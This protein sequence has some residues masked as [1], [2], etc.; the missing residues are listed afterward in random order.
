MSCIQSIICLGE[1]RE[2]DNGYHSYDF[3]IKLTDGKSYRETF[4]DRAGRQSTQELLNVL[5]ARGYDIRGVQGVS[6]WPFHQDK[7]W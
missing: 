4:H 2:W 1:N 6:K 7:R 5:S 3:S